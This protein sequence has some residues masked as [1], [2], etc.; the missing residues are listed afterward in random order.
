MYRSISEPGLWKDMF[1]SIFKKRVREDGYSPVLPFSR[2]IDKKHLKIETQ[3][4]YQCVSISRSQFKDHYIG[5]IQN[6]AMYMQDAKAMSDALT[7]ATDGLQK[8]M[9]ARLPYDRPREEGAKVEQL[10]KYAMFASYMLRDA[11]KINRSWRDK[12]GKKLLYPDFKMKGLQYGEVESPTY[13]NNL[14]SH[15]KQILPQS[16]AEWLLHDDEKCLVEVANAA[17]GQP[18]FIDGP[19][20]KVVKETPEVVDT[21]LAGKVE[22]VEDKDK[23][24]VVSKTPKAKVKKEKT[25]PSTVAVAPEESGDDGDFIPNPSVAKKKARSSKKKRKAKTAN[26]EKR[27]S[28]GMDQ[29]ALKL[30]AMSETTELGKKGKKADSSSIELTDGLCVAEFEDTLKSVEEW[31]YTDSGQKAFPYQSTIQNYLNSKETKFKVKDFRE[32]LKGHGYEVVV[33]DKKT[34]MTVPETENV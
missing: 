21:A 1:R 34:V 26:T 28:L 6:V 32:V 9:L 22:I 7:R 29:M 19:I 11:A 14:I 12:N 10:W 31:R 27:E 3:K 25:E 17:S 8:T 13:A 5:T 23:E 24:V 15:L 2:V 4:L 16:S 20:K 18:C 30:N 33:L